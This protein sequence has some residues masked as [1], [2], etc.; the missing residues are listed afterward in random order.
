MTFSPDRAAG[1][2]RLHIDPPLDGVQL[3]T[4][5]ALQ[6]GECGDYKAA[7]KADF[8]DASRVRFAGAYPSGCGEKVW[9]VAYA[10]PPSFAAH[11]VAG[12]WRDLGGKL[13][14]RVRDG[15]LP[16]GLRPAFEQASPPLA[17]VVRDINKYSNN[18]MAQQVFLSLSLP[19]PSSSAAT[20]SPATFEA[21]REVVRQWWADRLPGVPT[22]TLENGSG[23]SRNERITAQALG[24]LLQSAYLSPVMPELMAS[25]PIAGVDGTLRRSKTRTAQGA[26]H[27]KTGS[28]RDVVAIAGYVLG[29]SGR[30][31]VLVAVVNHPTLANNARPVLNAL[32]DWTHKESP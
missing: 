6:T 8:S 18:V 14:G 5:V 31:Y 22:P 4:S 7:L 29:A 12:Q 25:L 17:D 23:L 11:A 10:D 30:R 24:Q 2:A 3:P 1:L 26:A 20:A 27:L 9:P 32:I 21:S 28:L 19:P 13:G 15:K 16:A